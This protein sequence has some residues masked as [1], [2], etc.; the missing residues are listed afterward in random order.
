MRNV[1][2][3]S[4][5]LHL[6]ADKLT[7]LTLLVHSQWN[8]LALLILRNIPVNFHV[9]I[10]LIQLLWPKQYYWWWIIGWCLFLQWFRICGQ[11]FKPRRCWV[12]GG[13]WG[14]VELPEG[15]E[16]RRQTS[17]ELGGLCDLG[18]LRV[19]DDVQQWNLPAAALFSSWRG[20]PPPL[21]SCGFTATG[22]RCC[23]SQLTVSWCEP[24]RACLR[25]VTHILTGLEG[26]ATP[27]WNLNQRRLVLI[28][29]LNNSEGL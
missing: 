29:S 28:I 4:T 25:D 27:G 2:T 11:D 17:S 10:L 13:P 3:C 14:C 20:K 15:H 7:K 6:P 1:R 16:S 18:P 23:A 22:R 26:R 8:N 9:C 19:G 5:A 21:H 12:P 24:K